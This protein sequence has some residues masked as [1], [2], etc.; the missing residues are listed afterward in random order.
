MWYVVFFKRHPPPPFRFEE[1]QDM[2][3]RAFDLDDPKQSIGMADFLGELEFTLGRVS[4]R[5]GAFF[6]HGIL[7]VKFTA[8]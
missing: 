5:T 6:F 7:G 4:S 8:P 1:K 2:R 3:L